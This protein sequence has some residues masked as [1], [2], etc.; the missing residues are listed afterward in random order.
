VFATQNPIELEG[1]YPLPEAQLD[2][3]MFEIVVDYLSEDDEVSVVRQTTAAPVGR[4]RPVVTAEELVAFH[5]LVRRVPVSDAVARYA[6]SL[7]RASRPMSPNAPEEVKRFVAFGASVRAPQ[8][9]IL[10]CKARALMHGR[11]HVGFEDVRALVRPALRHRV[12]LNFHAQSERVTV[13]QLVDRL[14]Q[15]V[16]VPSSRM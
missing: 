11:F 16:P 2:R 5:A 12:I 3:F 4:L 14:L 13:D 10:A 1:T 8:Q 15:A 7:A 6:V 9:L